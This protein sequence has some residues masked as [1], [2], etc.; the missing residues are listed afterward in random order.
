MQS[1]WFVC[2]NSVNLRCWI[3]SKSRDCLC[4]RTATFV[5]QENRHTTKLTMSYQEGHFCRI[6]F[7]VSFSF[8]FPFFTKHQN[9]EIPKSPVQWYIQKT[10]EWRVCYPHAWLLL[11]F[12]D[13]TLNSL[14]ALTKQLWQ[15]V[16]GYSSACLWAKDTMKLLHAIIN[17]CKNNQCTVN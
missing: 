14:W 1:L 16:H 10:V 2:L 6:T 3:T 12:I 13:F 7:F 8:A 11:S 4:I 17:Q 15:S 5:L 9:P